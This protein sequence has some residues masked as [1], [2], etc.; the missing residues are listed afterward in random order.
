MAEDG[1]WHLPFFPFMLQPNQVHIWRAPL[2]LSAE[3]VAHFAR[4][5]SADETARA[6]RFVFDQDRRRYTVAR[7]ILR[8]LLSAYLGIDAESISFAYGPQGKP[9]LCPASGHPPLFFNLSHSHELV[10]FGMTRIG[11]IGIDVEY[12][13]AM[14][15]MD[16]VEMDNLVDEV[17]SPRERAVF[18]ALPP[19]ERQLAFYNGW[20]RKE[21]FIKAVGDGLAYPLHR[22]DV[23]LAP[24]QPARLLRLHDQPGA[25]RRWQMAA[26]TPSPD[27]TGAVVVET[28]VE[29]TAIELSLRPFTPSS[30]FGKPTPSL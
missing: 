17:F 27:Y 14:A 13:R 7:G 8:T 22:F 6:R 23:S 5:L 9:F 15:K 28:P 11:R 16:N 29:N 20:T 19:L 3:Q 30:A 1:E 26:F 18:H 4:R 12:R 2:D 21:A 25:H 10:V 24:G